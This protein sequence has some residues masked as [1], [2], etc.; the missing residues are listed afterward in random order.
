MSITNA[1]VA[2][3]D[4]APV[5]MATSRL[6]RSHGIEAAAFADGSVFLDRLSATPAYRPA[7]VMR[8]LN[9]P[10]LNGFD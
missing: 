3:V 7:Y 8:N 6:L 5:A 1:R 4:D 9:M 10:G 2:V